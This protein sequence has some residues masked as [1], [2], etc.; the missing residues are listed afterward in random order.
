M[1]PAQD[2]AVKLFNALARL[3]DSV[4]PCGGGFG[5][6]VKHGGGETNNRGIALVTCG[7]IVEPSG[8]SDRISAAP[9]LHD[10]FRVFWIVER[11][12]LREL[13]LPL[14]GIHRIGLS[15][16]AHVG[17]NRR[18]CLVGFVDTAQEL[19]GLGWVGLCIVLDAEVEQICIAVI[20]CLGERPDG[21][22]FRG[23][24]GPRLDQGTGGIVAQAARRELFD[25]L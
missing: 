25:P 20:F 23:G 12:G 9:F 3:G 17:F 4:A 8:G 16:S 1:T 2:G 5:V 7:G 24:G 19:F 18:G 6:E 15:A 21:G 22:G 13:N 14:H 11:V 10:D